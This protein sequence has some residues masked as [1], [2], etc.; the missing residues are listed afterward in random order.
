MLVI[1]PEGEVDLGP[2]QPECSISAVYHV[3]NGRKT[4]YAQFV[5]ARA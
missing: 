5:E 1:V 2:Q 4:P 3:E